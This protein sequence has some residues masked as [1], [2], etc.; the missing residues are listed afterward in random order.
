MRQSDETMPTP[1]PLA[2]HPRDGWILAEPYPMRRSTHR[3]F[4]SIIKA[5]IPPEPVLPGIVEQ[6]DDGARRLMRYMHPVMAFLFCVMVHVLDWS[7]LWRLRSWRRLRGLSPERG[8]AVLGEL[9][10]SRFSLI[11]TLLVGAKGAILSTYFD[12]PEV[13]A[14]LHYDPRPFMLGRIALRQRLVSGGKP[15]EADLIGPGPGGLP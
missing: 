4:L 9:A 1:E 15:T 12:L 6:V 8:S 2:R 11:R 5:L 7:P 14:R 13:H 3:A 10:E